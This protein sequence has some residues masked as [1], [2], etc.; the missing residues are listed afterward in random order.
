MQQRDL[1]QF[2]NDLIPDLTFQQAWERTGCN[3]NISISPAEIHQNS[4]LLNAVTAPHVMIRTAVLA[5]AA[6]PGV[7]PPVG[8]EAR[9]EQGEKQPYLPNRKWVEDGSV[10]E[11]MPARR[12]SRLYGVNHF[13]VSQTNPLVLPFL[14]SP[15]LVGRAGRLL[16]T[17]AAN[18]TRESLRLTRELSNPYAHRWPRVAM[19]ANTFYS[20]A[21]QDYRGDINILPDYRFVNPR[22]LL[23]IPHEEEIIAL[24]R[25]GERSTWPQI[26]TIRITTKVGRTLDRLLT[27]ATEGSGEQQRILAGTGD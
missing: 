6:V 21:L 24:E 16:Y 5:S 22:K 13:I 11:D 8:L 2:I 25:A 26:E 18:I 23:S 1:R 9:N 17:A 19:Y 12:L 15:L 10:S 20:V 7:F 3:I 14:D 27:H 4:R